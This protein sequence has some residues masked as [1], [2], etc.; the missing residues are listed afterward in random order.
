MEYMKGRLLVTG[1][2]VFS[3]SATGSTLDEA[4]SAA[5]SGVQAIIFDDYFIAK[6]L[7]QGNNP[8]LPPL[9]PMS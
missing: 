1:G 4:V 9:S 2:R 8:S 3:V 5:Y 7:R 6:K